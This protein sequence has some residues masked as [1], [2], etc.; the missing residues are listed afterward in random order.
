MTDHLIAILKGTAWLYRRTQ[1]MQENMVIDAL[2]TIGRDWPWQ[3]GHGV[4]ARLKRDAVHKYPAALFPSR[5][6]RFDLA[7]W[8]R[9]ISIRFRFWYHRSLVIPSERKASAILRALWKRGLLICAPENPA[10]Y[11][12]KR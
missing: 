10:L 5:V 3:S 12:L 11:Q 1:K 6:D 9:Q 7:S 4:V 2:G 8:I